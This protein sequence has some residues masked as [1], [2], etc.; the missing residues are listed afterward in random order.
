MK[1]KNPNNLPEALVLAASDEKG[2]SYSRNRISIT[3]LIG[4]PLA[5]NLKMKYHS[6]A[7]SDVEDM[8]WLLIGKAFHLLMDKY[9]PETHTSEEKIEIEVDGMTLV[10]IPDSY[11]NGILYDYKVTSVY[12]FLLGEKLEW[13]RQLNCYRWMLH[14]KGVEIRSL[15]II[16]IL[17]DYMARKANESDYP[18]KPL[19]AVNIPMWSLEETESY[20]KQRLDVHKHVV[21]C[22]DEERWSKPTT[23]AVMLKG[24]KKAKRV[25]LSHDD[26]AKWMVNNMN[27]VK[28]AYIEE[29]PGEDSKCLRYCAYS[30]YCD[31]NIYR[32]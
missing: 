5:R 11:G 4:S 8:S 20:I 2:H 23:Y 15:Q 7:S 1:I 21:P 16:A 27:D 31:H 17:R 6:D 24:Q 29:R 18:K 22:T 3:D 25:L 28:K 12:A 10:G 13:E 32:R 26:A 19:I 14:K 30:K 9:T